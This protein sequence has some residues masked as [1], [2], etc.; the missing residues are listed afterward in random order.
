MIVSPNCL[1]G[2]GFNMLWW[3]VNMVSVGAAAAAHNKTATAV[4]LLLFGTL[5]AKS[6]LHS[7]AI[8]DI[9]TDNKVPSDMI[10]TWS[11]CGRREIV[12]CQTGQNDVK[13]ALGITYV[14]ATPHLT[15]LRVEHYG[16][17]LSE[18]NKWIE[19]NL[20][21]TDINFP[22]NLSVHKHEWYCLRF[23]RI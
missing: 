8:D 16:E 19:E 10:S 20:E 1:V 23:L 5:P 6:P 21:G 2:H 9:R 4:L 7:E 18:W 14:S 22:S 13:N 17:K 3:I 11:R 15:S 12:M